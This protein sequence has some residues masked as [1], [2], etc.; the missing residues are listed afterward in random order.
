MTT[1]SSPLII[2][3]NAALQRT[4]SFPCVVTGAVNR[5]SGLEIGIGGKGQN[6]QLAASIMA[7]ASPRLP[8]TRLAQFVG[9]GFEGD[10]LFHLQKAWGVLT[11]ETTIRSTGR[12]RTCFT[13]LD[14]TSKDATELIEPSEPVSEEDVKKLLD[15]LKDVYATE[16]ATGIA[17]MGRYVNLSKI[18]AVC[19]TDICAC[20]HVRLHV[21][22][23]V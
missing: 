21:C 2:G 16:K 23:C 4:A 13:L 18:Y 6:A 10:Q 15:T 19:Y 22:M 3:L 11:S 12:C 7:A 9:Q 5:A 20:K 14:Q 8:E 1:A 17:I